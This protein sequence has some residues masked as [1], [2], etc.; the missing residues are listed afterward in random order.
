MKHAGR[1]GKAALKLIVLALLATVLLL[2]LVRFA[3]LPGESLLVLMGLWFLFASF[4][5]YFFRDPEPI[6]PSDTNLILAPAHGTVDAIES[7]GGPEFMGGECQRISIFL[8]VFNVHVQNAPVGGTVTFFKYT[9]GQF[10]NALNADS[11]VHN[12]NVLFG[13]QTSEPAPRVIGVRLIA[14][15]L[16]RRI[17]P[18]A[19]QGDQVAAG[20]RV[21]LIQF[22]SRVDLYL[23]SQARIEVKLN[24][25]VV[26]GQTVMA[27]FE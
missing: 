1:A 19:Q 21:G 15:L 5:L 16:A 3:H 25:R 18:F 23:P 6:V 20:E 2:V 9:K 8:S 11:A 10:L 4:T 13:I 22:G 17:V 27:R 26:G 24:D 14:G 7:A 12:E